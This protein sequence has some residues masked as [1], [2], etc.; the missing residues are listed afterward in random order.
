MKATDIHVMNEIGRDGFTHMFDFD[1][2]N[3]K[4]FWKTPAH[5]FQRLIGKEAGYASKERGGNFR[6]KVLCRGHL[7]QRSRLMYFV[8]HNKIPSMLIDHINGD[9][10][11]DRISN[12]READVAQN[13]WNSNHAHKTINP[14]LP[15]GVFI[16][17]NYKRYRAA[18]QVR[19]K[20]II[21]GYFDTPELASQAYQ[22]ARKKYFGEFA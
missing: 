8:Y 18:I 1:F 10:L 15:R 16:G 20:A 5:N 9:S 4:V 3:G 17:P 14:H 19:R 2:E 6:W 7:L 22:D 12:L 13:G 21:L 11:D